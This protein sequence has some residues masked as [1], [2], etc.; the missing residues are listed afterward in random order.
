MIG[1]SEE[2]IRT[3]YLEKAVEIY[4]VQGGTQLI[5][6]LTTLDYANAIAKAAVKKVVDYI[7]SRTT[8]GVFLTDILK[9][10]RLELDV[11]E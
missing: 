2:E 7:E 9:E 4:G 6:Q 11:T 8:D 5:S 3:I 10:V 1:L